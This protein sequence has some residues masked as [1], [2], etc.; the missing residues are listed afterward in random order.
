MGR[1]GDPE[2]L[3]RLAAGL[4]RRADEVREA[5]LD[6][7]AD[8]DRARW[9]SDAA[10]VYRDRLADDRVRVDA[11]AAELDRAADLLRRHA[12]EV[13]ERLAAIAAAER[14]VRD[15]LQRQADPDGLLGPAV[16]EVLRD[17]PVPG[18]VGWLEKS[19]V[20]RRLGG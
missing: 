16:G 6:H 9:V 1:Y 10:T 4:H 19:T 2:E 12:G 13:R 17:L 15:W 14:S 11:A 7:Q 5:A 18:A 8:A 20:L 3:D